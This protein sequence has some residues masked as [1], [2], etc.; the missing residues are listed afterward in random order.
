MG[1]KF[2]I[3]VWKYIEWKGEWGAEQYWAGESYRTALKKLR[4]AKSEGYG[5]VTLHYR[6]D[7]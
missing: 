7:A 6:G 3:E 2:E 5:C 4:E 1:S